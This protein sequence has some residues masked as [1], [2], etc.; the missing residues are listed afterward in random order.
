[1]HIHEHFISMCMRHGYEWCFVIVSMSTSTFIRNSTMHSLRSRNHKNSIWSRID[2]DDVDAHTIMPYM[3]TT[4]VEIISM[5]RR[6][7][8]STMPARVLT[9]CRHMSFGLM[10]CPQTLS[11]FFR[12]F[13]WL[14]ACEFSERCGTM[15]VTFCGHMNRKIFLQFFFFS[16]AFSFLFISF[17]FVRLIAILLRLFSIP[18][19]HLVPVRFLPSQWYSDLIVKT[20]RICMCHWRT[21]TP[22]YIFALFLFI[23]II[24]NRYHCYFVLM[25]RDVSR[26]EMKI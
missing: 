24:I 21:R 4:A 16:S 18:L 1:M 3:Y 25:L 23:I 10:V 8:K 22:L 26:F 14:R 20:E 15:T 12:C 17:S 9:Q 2:D 6:R 11:P 7:P 19:R 13:C 5:K